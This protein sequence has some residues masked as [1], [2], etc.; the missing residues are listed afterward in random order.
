MAQFLAMTVEE[1]TERYTRLRPD[2]LG[3][4][5]EEK[6]N[7]ECIFLDGMDCRVQTVKPQQCRDFP[8]QWNFSGWREQCKAIPRE[9]A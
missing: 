8:N 2:R 6:P 9:V 5:L 1:F 4:L 7:Q 3:L